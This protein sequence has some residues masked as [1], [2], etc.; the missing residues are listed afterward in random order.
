MCI[1]HKMFRDYESRI[2]ESKTSNS[3]SIPSWNRRPS[4]LWN[5]SAAYSMTGRSFRMKLSVSFFSTIT[6]FV[7]F[8]S[9]LIVWFDRWQAEISLTN[10]QI[11]ANG[12]LAFCIDPYPNAY[13]KDIVKAVLLATVA[14]Y[15]LRNWPAQ[16]VNLHLHQYFSSAREWRLPCFCSDQR[17]D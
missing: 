6:S 17:R 16:M 14:R 8:F 7:H 11:F 10:L 13:R 5:W 4:V 1:N 2:A 3:W 15:W 9:D 12:A